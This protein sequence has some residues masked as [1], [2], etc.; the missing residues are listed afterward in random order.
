M[1]M[2]MVRVFGLG[3]FTPECTGT[4]ECGV[5]TARTAGAMSYCFLERRVGKFA[6]SKKSGV[7]K[8][9]ITKEIV[10]TS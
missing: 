10:D 7:R 4:G 1:A 6:L 2:E 5:A 9:D 3:V 8:R